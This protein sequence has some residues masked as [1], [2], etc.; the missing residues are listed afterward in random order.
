[1]A[2]CELQTY[3]P[4]NAQVLLIIWRVQKCNFTVMRSINFDCKVNKGKADSVRGLGGPLTSRLPHYL[5]NRLKDG[6]EVVNLTRRPP[7]TPPPRNI[8]GTHFC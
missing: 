6:G 7:F 5:Y 2:M 3:E 4:I 8:P 1:M